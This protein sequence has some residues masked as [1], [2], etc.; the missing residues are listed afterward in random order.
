MAAQMIMEI[1]AAFAGVLSDVAVTHGSY[2]CRSQGAGSSRVSGRGESTRPRP[3]GAER[4]RVVYLVGQ[5]GQVGEHAH[6]VNP[7]PLTASM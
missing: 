5:A 2:G 4:G 3:A 7:E 1:L 6:W